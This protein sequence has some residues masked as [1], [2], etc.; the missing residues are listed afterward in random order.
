MAHQTPALATVDGLS[1]QTRQWRRP[2]ARATVILVH[3]FAAS[4]KDGAVIRQA[5]ALHV[6]GFDVITY[7]S[8]GHGESDGLCTLGDLERH[9]VA[10]AVAGDR[11]SDR[12][13]VLV[14]A[15]MGAISVL[16]YAACGDARVDGVVAVSCPAA[17]RAPRSAQGMLL[18]ALTQTRLGRSVA[19]RRMR[20]RL[21]PVWTNPEP[22]TALVGRID[23]PI[24]LVHGQRD[25]FIPAAAAVELYRHARDPRRLDLV[26]GMGH[27]YDLLGVA[28]VL[29]AVEWVLV[30][31]AARPRIP[32]TV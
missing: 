15:S 30:A 20:V 19:D 5:E 26:P 12:P 21:S 13:V 16:R 9:D 2:D 10:A 1:L 27:A 31:G 25:R 11:R 18:A 29:A 17:W 7:D 32:L 22:P 23:A 3:G 4:R 28:P 24:A 6:A 8:R 14:G